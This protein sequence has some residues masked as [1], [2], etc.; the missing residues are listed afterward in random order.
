[1]IVPSRLGNTLLDLASPAAVRPF[2]VR[3]DLWQARIVALSVFG[4]YVAGSARTEQIVV[5]GLLAWVVVT[6]WPRMMKVRCGP[7]P[8]LLAWCGLYAVMLIATAFRPFDPAFYG[9]QPAS[10]A[11]A[12]LALPVAL[13]I[14]TWYWTLR[15]EPV[16]LLRAA[17][18]V[19]VAGMCANALLEMMQ[20]TAGKAV[21]AGFL[22]H[23]WD[24]SA[25]GGPIGQ[26]GSGM[27][28][29]VA[30]NA[31]SNGRY[32]GIFDQPAEAGIAYGVALLCLIWLARGSSRRPAL[33]T[34]AAVALATG[35][36]LTLSKVFL[37]AAVPL[38]VLTVLRGRARIRA[39]LVAAAV[40]GALWLAGSAGLLPAWHLGGVVLGS[41]AHPDGSLV[42]RYTA[43]RYGD[44]GTLG[45]TASDVLHASPWAGFGA[46]GLNVAYD[47]LWLE[48]FVVS[49]IIGVVLAAAM[50]V[51]LAARWARLKASIGRAEWQLAGGV[52]VLAIG[53]S[54]GIPSLTANRAATLLWLVLGLLVCARGRAAIS[55]GEYF[56]HRGA[57]LACDQAAPVSW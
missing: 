22:P 39:V 5:V 13:M 45:P 14:L 15:S 21:V 30:A 25:V 46:A 2:A 11:L 50:L 33:V 10:H 18:P 8:F 42:T 55:G 43:G 38:A 17:A 47:S 27:L 6:G 26:P 19:I 12:A 16:Q 9:P 20:V 7:A 3:G 48:L 52:L 51:L 29:S 37:L 54:L 40:A 23:F 44:G 49:G 24:A 4:P 56:R 41:L 31:A 57:E 32:T 35:G 34:A 53:A 28:G 36:T 1:V